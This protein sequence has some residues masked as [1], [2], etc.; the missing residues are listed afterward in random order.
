MP[1][2]DPIEATLDW[3]FRTDLQPIADA[4]RASAREIA[5]ALPV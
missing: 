1:D 3:R 5:A 4:I 2:Q